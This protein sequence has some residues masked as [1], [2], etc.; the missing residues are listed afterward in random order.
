MNANSFGNIFRLTSFGESHGSAMGVVIEGCPAG[1][2]WN[3]KLLDYNLRR[4]RP[5]QSD[6]VSDRNEADQVEVLSGVF[7]GKTLGTPIALMVKNLDARSQDYKAVELEPRKGH[8]DDLW[9]DKFG[10]S[11][12]R[13][14][15]RASGRETLSRV[16]AGSVAQMLN[17]HVMPEM[18]LY[19]FASAIGPIQMNEEDLKY[20]DHEILSI[21]SPITHHTATEK[22]YFLQTAFTTWLDLFASRLPQKT[23]SEEAAKLLTAAKEDGKSYGG[24]IQ[25]WVDGARRGLGQPVFHKL[26]ADL[27]SAL[28]GIGATCAVEIGDGA[29]APLAEGSEFHQRE[30]SP[31]GGQRGGITTGERLSIRLHFKPTSSVLDVAKKGR[32]DPCIV[33]R[34]LPVVEA[35]LQL[36]IA[37]HL[38]WSRLDRI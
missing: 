14:G 28:M 30:S 10:F 4:R 29:E 23:K 19:A 32:H 38:L 5:G 2:I 27:A 16:L 6:L 34:A 35:M 8:A 24:S 7:E 11:D 17:Q 13:G 31:Y 1:L 22:V 12:A 9:F 21:Q 37:D 15:G 26:K 3:Q 20:V 33:I 18:K 25:I 36:V